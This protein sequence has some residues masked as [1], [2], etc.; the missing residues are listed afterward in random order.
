MLEEIKQCSLQRRK[1]KTQ[2]CGQQKKSHTGQQTAPYAGRGRNLSSSGVRGICT[3]PPV[4]SCMSPESQGRP[5]PV[6]LLR[7]PGSDEKPLNQPQDSQ[8]SR[9]RD[10]VRPSRATWHLVPGRTPCAHSCPGTHLIFLP[11][12]LLAAWSPRPDLSASSSGVVSAMPYLCSEVPVCL[13]NWLAFSIQV[14][15]SPACNRSPLPLSP[16]A[17]SSLSP[18]SL[19]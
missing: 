14:T 17:F 4:S 3:Q 11:W 5:Q 10:K 15:P 1:T 13:W 12:V 2:P 16:S 7:A 9:P 6:S 8:V 18:L 19:L